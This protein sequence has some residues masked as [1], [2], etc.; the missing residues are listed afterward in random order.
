MRTVLWTWTVRLEICSVLRM[1]IQPVQVELE[2]WQSKATIRVVAV[3]FV[4]TLSV[5]FFSPVYF[6]VQNVNINKVCILI[7]CLNFVILFSLHVAV[8]LFF[9]GSGSPKDS[10]PALPRSGLTSAGC[11]FVPGP[12]LWTSA[13]SPSH[14]TLE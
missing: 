1:H 4:C 8:L 5:Q 12:A 2:F 6:L 10:Q 9:P 11:P 7:F 3:I 14:V 13:S